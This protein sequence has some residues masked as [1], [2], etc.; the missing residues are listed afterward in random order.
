MSEKIYNFYNGSQNVE[1]IDKQ[2]NHYHYYGGQRPEVSVEESQTVD[3]LMPIFFNNREEVENFLVEIRSSTPVQVIAAVNSRLEKKVI[4][5]LSC[6]KPL[7]EVLNKHGYYDKTLTNWNA[8]IG[9]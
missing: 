3:E 8:Q 1:H 6:H 9:K 2:E 5:D 4:S 7:W